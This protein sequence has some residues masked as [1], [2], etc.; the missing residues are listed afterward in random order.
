MGWN[1]LTGRCGALYAMLPAF[2]ALALCWN[3][4]PDKVFRGPLRPLR[5]APEISGAAVVWLGQG[6]CAVIRCKGPAARTGKT[7]FS[8]G[9]IGAARSAFASA[10]VAVSIRFAVAGPGLS[11]RA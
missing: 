3:R 1:A 4:L 10:G 6:P 11:C 9:W 8:F 5:A 7:R 2:P